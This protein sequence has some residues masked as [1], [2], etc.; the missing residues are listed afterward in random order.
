MLL[1]G[2]LGFQPI[3]FDIETR[4][5]FKWK[6]VTRP[7]YHLALFILLG[8]YKG[9][10]K[11]AILSLRWSKIDLVREKIDFRREHTAETKK[12]R[13]FC[14]LPTRLKPHLVRAKGEGSNIGL[15]IQWESS[16]IE[17]I[18]TVLN[19]AVRRV[20]LKG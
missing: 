6:R 16:A 7:Q 5:S 8:L 19:N 13:G 11:E 17:N 10:R 20:Y 2:A 3:V 4:F 9:R 14:R 18:K 1:A 15:V 12:K